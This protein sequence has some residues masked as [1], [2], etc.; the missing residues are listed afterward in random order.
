VPIGALN[1][2]QQQTLREVFEK[3]D[4]SNSEWSDVESLLKAVGKVTEGRG[5]RIRA[6][7]N[8]KVGTFHRPHPKKET[9]KGAVKS[10][11]RFLKEA[12]VKP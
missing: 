6:F 2:K 10:L 9:D 5:S 1:S 8:G 7:V 12:G 3:P 11:R 4:R